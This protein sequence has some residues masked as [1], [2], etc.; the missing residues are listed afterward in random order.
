[1]N[2]ARAK[3]NANKS[4]PAVKSR[5][6]QET[7]ARGGRPS[8]NSHAL[9]ATL[10]NTC[11]KHVVTATN[12]VNRLARN[13]CQQ[14]GLLVLEIEPKC[15]QHPG[16]KGAPLTN[17][18]VEGMQACRA[19]AQLQAGDRLGLLCVCQQECTCVTF[20]HVSLSRGWVRTARSTIARNGNAPSVQAMELSKHAERRRSKRLRK[21]NS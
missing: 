6:C 14:A 11:R 2:I 5:V 19:C 16:C 7:K 9:R 15:C 10:R 17:T 1:M 18:H 3:E 13:G 21:E 8:F 4:G 12:S 20:G